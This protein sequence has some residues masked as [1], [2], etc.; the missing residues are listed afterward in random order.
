MVKR[1]AIAAAACLV[2]ATTAAWRS[3]HRAVEPFYFIQFSDPQL[4]MYRADSDFVHDAANFEFAV[5]SAN[6]L[7]PAFVIVTG[8]L[9]NKP[10]DSAQVAAY[11]RIV[12]KLDRRIKLYNLP[13]NHDV[14]NIPTPAS[15]AK[16]HRQFGPDHYVF[17]SGSLAGVVLNSSL[18][19]QPDSAPKENAAQEKWLEDTLAALS[20]E[21]GTQIVIFQHHPW[22]L[23][24]PDEAA[25]YFNIPVA[26]RAR[27][28]ALF[29]RYGVRYL[30]SGHYHQNSIAHDGSIEMVTTGPVGKP[31]GDVPRSG[32][33][34]AV[35]SDSG[36]VHK[37]F[38]FSDIPDRLPVLK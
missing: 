5:A 9:V 8:D 6:R 3:D 29:K 35:V 10:G 30:F 19:Q 4:G 2:V 22:F 12:A 26:T 1:I 14:G 25:Q 18:L 37:F 27:Y 21:K 31:F 13:G 16:Y 32:F 23:T 20:R 24:A 33:R 7:R 11:H 38:D 34:I 36:I 28:L 15:I 17:R